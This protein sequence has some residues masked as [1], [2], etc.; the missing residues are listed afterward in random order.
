[1]QPEW[2]NLQL[3]VGLRR[4]FEQ[5]NGI[6]DKLSLAIDSNNLS[7]DKLKSIAKSHFEKMRKEQ[8]RARSLRN[9]LVSDCEDDELIEISN[10]LPNPKLSI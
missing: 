10:S 9:L 2:Q 8:N 6:V 1:M 4:G 5:I 7:E 3:V